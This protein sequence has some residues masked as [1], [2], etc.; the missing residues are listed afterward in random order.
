MYTLGAD[1]GLGCV[2]QGHFGSPRIHFTPWDGSSRDEDRTIH[3]RRWWARTTTE[4][5]NTTEPGRTYRA[6][7]RVGQDIRSRGGHS[8]PGMR[9]RAGH[10]EPVRPNGANQTQP[11]LALRCYASPVGSLCTSRLTNDSRRWP[12][13]HCAPPEVAPCAGGD[14]SRRFR[15]RHLKTPVGGQNCPTRIECIPAGGA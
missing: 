2:P 3:D 15:S 10:T 9:S 6:R 8:E 5:H 14:D 13:W 12:R 1:V 4:C 11:S 7:P